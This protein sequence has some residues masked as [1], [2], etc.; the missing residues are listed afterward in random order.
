[1]SDEHTNITYTPL[2]EAYFK[3]WGEKCQCY[4]W[5]YTHAERY[6]NKRKTFIDLPSNV[7]SLAVGFLQVGATSIFGSEAMYSN[8]ALGIGSLL[9]SIMNM[10]KNYFVLDKKAENCR[11]AAISYEK[12][13]RFIVIEMGLPKEQRMRPNEL[14]KTV[15]N[16][17]NR[18]KETSVALPEMTI[19]AFKKRFSEHKYASISKPEITNGLSEIKVYSEDKDSSLSPG[20][21]LSPKFEV[22]MPKAETKI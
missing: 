4:T 18:L 20:T 7:L 16:E 5:L 21:G 10:T 11:I 9:V 12:L 3:N 15:T 1:M 13:Y 17:I 2:L 8:V 14:L 6:Y 19:E 22:E